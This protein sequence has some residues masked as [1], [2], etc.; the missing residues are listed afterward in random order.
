MREIISLVLGCL[1]VII[2]LT[3]IIVYFRKAHHG[4]STPNAT[5]WMIWSG[6][7]LVNL[8]TYQ[9]GTGDWVKAINA[10]IA[11]GNCFFMFSFCLFRGRMKE[12]RKLDVVAICIAFIALA[13]W[14][15]SGI[16]WYGNIFI[17]CAIVSSFIVT[18]MGIIKGTHREYSLPWALWTI[19]HTIT[20]FIVLLRWNNQPISLLYPLL[21]IALNATVTL[22]AYFK[23]QQIQA[24]A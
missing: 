10:Y 21:G 20:L 1:L 4:S 15:G 22:T 18:L 7:S 6:V 17:Q 23:N 11:T 12:I 24:A 8:L 14:F 16:A 13:C 2:N 5:S 9:F 3:A 19:C